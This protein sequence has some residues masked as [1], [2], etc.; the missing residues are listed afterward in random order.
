MLEDEGLICDPVML[1]LL[2]L[3]VDFFKAVQKKC[4]LEQRLFDQRGKRIMDMTTKYL[5]DKGELNLTKL[6]NE[7]KEK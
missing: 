2:N 5:N 4:V 6:L 1:S 7:K 3:Y